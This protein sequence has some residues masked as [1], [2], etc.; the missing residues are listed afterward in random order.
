MVIFYGIFTFDEKINE[1]G[2][3]DEFTMKVSLL[4]GLKI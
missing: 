4:K 1:N 3:R 2:S